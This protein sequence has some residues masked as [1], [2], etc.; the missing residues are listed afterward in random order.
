M[1]SSRSTGQWS[2]P[3]VKSL[4]KCLLEDILRYEE[5][6]YR[7]GVE[8]VTANFDINSFSLSHLK[9]EYIENITNFRLASFPKDFKEVP[10]PI[11]LQDVYKN[12]Q[13]YNGYG[14]LLISFRNTKSKYETILIQTRNLLNALK[15]KSNIWDCLLLNCGPNALMLI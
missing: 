9:E 12:Q 6:Y 1:G 5:Q 3:G 14:H 10:F 2:L 15:W 4:L 8:I 7:P 13:I 11:E